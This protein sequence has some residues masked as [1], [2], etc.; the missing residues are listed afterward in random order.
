MGQPVVPQHPFGPSSAQHGFGQGIGQGLSHT[1]SALPPTQQGFGQPV[2][3][4]VPEQ[5]AESACAAIIFG[6]DAVC[7]V[8]GQPPIPP[9]QAFAGAS[10]SAELLLA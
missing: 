6:Q 2:V 8:I 10:L 1:P 9:W 5:P 7:A 3:Q 4:G